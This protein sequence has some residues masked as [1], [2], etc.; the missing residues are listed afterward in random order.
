MRS[1]LLPVLFMLLWVSSC[2][3]VEK[4]TVYNDRTYPDLANAKNVRIKHIPGKEFVFYR[5]EVV[6]T[7]ESVIYARCWEKKNSEPVDYKFNKQEVVIVSSTFSGSAATNYFLITL[8]TVG[9]LIL[10][11]IILSK[12]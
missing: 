1:M 10:I 12:A 2:S 9:L 7:D 5:M 6:K 3:Q 8:I 11:P 4:T